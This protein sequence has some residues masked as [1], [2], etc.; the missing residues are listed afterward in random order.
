MRH[1]ASAAGPPGGRGVWTGV[2]TL[3]HTRN[4][5]APVN[6]EKLERAPTLQNISGCTKSIKSAGQL[7]APKTRDVEHP[8][9]E[10]N[11]KTLVV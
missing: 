5:I 2:W 11:C 7:V 3:E 1:A 8:H 4:A 6:V 10:T 9:F